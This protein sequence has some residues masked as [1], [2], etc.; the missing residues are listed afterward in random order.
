MD[1]RS[2]AEAADL[3]AEHTGS[4]AKWQFT[5]GPWPSGNSRGQI[6]GGSATLQLALRKGD[7]AVTYVEYSINGGASWTALP[8]DKAT[9]VQGANP[10]QYRYNAPA[11][12]DWTFLVGDIR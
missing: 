8:N 6:Y 10:L 9:P 2:N 7:G 12:V 5:I 11:G 4:G 3:S 1:K